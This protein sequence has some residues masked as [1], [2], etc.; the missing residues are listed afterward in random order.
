MID[1]RTHTTG[2]GRQIPKTKQVATNLRM[3]FW[4]AKKTNFYN[5]CV[6]LILSDRSIPAEVVIIGVLTV[7][8]M[9]MIGNT[10]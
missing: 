9:T 5:K 7:M 4:R 3:S 2:L 8:V 6:E 1:E 10:Y